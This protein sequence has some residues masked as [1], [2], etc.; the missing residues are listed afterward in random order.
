[1][2]NSF[3]FNLPSYKKLFDKKNILIK[4]SKNKSFGDY[5]C[6]FSMKLSKIININP[7]I[8]SNLI[9]KDLI[10]FDIFFKVEIKKPGFINLFLSKEYLEFLA[11]LFIS[12]SEYDTIIMPVAFRNKVIIDYSS[13]NIAKNMHVGHLRSTIIGDCIK[14]ILNALGYFTSPVNHI[15]DW[16]TQF[17]ILIEY[18]KTYK[19]EF[20]KKNNANINQL[21]SFYKDGKIKFDENSDFRFRATD[22]VL[23]LQKGN[24]M[25]RKIWS[26][27]C[28]ISYISFSKIYKLL[29]IQIKEK[30]ESYYNSILQDTLNKL[31][32]KGF[33]MRSNNAECVYVKNFFNKTENLLPII[34]KKKDGGFNYS[35]T[36]LAALR[37]RVEYSGASW[38]IYCV[39]V[40][41]SQHFNMIFKTINMFINLHDKVK[42]EHIPFG[43][44]LR[45]DGKKFKT[46]EGEHKKL[47]DLLMY[48]VKKSFL[49][50]KARNYSFSSKEINNISLI[51]GINSIKY[52]DLSCMRL[53]NYKFCYKNMLNFEGNTAIFI[54]YSYVRIISILNKFNDEEKICY[55]SIELRTVEEKILMLHIVKFNEVIIDVYKN[56]LPHILCDYLFSLSEKFNA[57]FHKCKIK[58]NVLNHSRILICKLTKHVLK[59]GMFMLGLK[60]LYKM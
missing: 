58:N 30:G 17:G 34:V 15:G 37:Y 59:K 60:I 10:N 43:L 50:F 52:N 27:F 56:F 1:M 19:K 14:N 12:K 31:N 46:R 48:A 57:F 20:T 54:C 51:L 8:I 26:K 5:Q 11:Y 13:P 18:I 2:I 40:G 23:L 33:L 36:D 4:P 35:S 39:D 47:I 21:S 9:L 32:K 7:M 55:S 41:Q 28:S 6:D 25:T 42:L 3:I 49:H 53:K 38:I 24:K 29:G 44:V 16:G 45:N 22:N